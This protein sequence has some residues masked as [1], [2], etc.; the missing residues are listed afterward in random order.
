MDEKVIKCFQTLGL[1]STASIDDI[2]FAY[3]SLSKDMQNGSLPWEK[4]KEIL[5]SYEYL[6]HYLPRDMHEEHEQKDSNKTSNAGSTEFSR[7]D[8]PEKNRYLQNMNIAPI[9]KRKTVSPLLVSISILVAAGLFFYFTIGLS[10]LNRIK[11]NDIDTS[12]IIK[13]IKPSIVTIKMGDSG[14]GSGFVVS[15]DGYIVTNGHVMKEKN[16]IVIFSDGFKTEVDLVMLDEEKDFALLKAKANR[17]YPFLALGDNNKCSEGDPV[18][19]A[20]APLSLEFSFTKGIISSTK[21]SLP[22]LNANLIQTDAAI[23]P[24][25]SGGPLINSNGEVIG[26]NFLK[27]ANLAIEGIGFAIAIND[28]K[29][30]IVNKRQMSDVELTSAIDREEK[31]LL[32]YNQM[33]NDD[34]S[35]MKDKILEEQWE[36]E[37]RRREFNE[38][39]E[40]ANRDLQEQKAKAE[41]RLQEEA[42]Q[43]RRR[44]Q[45]NA[46]ARRKFLTDCL[47]GATNQYQ[48]IWNEYCK[49]SNQQDNC[50]LPSNIAGALEQRHSQTRNECYRLNPQ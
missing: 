9:S 6:L 13:Q 33:P 4:S 37:R 23:N 20:G 21:R 25:N 22:F 42:E 32:E 50:A 49:K 1:P 19:A 16:A 24:G 14:T 15:S 45:E 30:H 38:K 18:V 41:R 39:V 34:V 17:D 31:K 12:S 35:K 28:V 10:T 2:E 40:A 36:R 3:Q 26:I 11:G 29:K 8:C 46:E 44:L 48:G 27:L 5:W 43:Y 7:T 47:Q